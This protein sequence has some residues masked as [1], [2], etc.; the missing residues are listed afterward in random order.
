MRQLDNTRSTVLCYGG[1]FLPLAEM[2][3]LQGIL[4]AHY[5]T[6]D[7]K[8]SNVDLDLPGNDQAVLCPGP[9]L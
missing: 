1:P 8:V 9:L 5:V 7:R 3:F 4:V 6:L 2:R